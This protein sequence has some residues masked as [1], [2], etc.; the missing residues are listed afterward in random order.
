MVGDMFVVVFVGCQWRE[1]E[2][3]EERLDEKLVVVR[4]A[5]GGF[6]VLTNAP[7]ALCCCAP[8]SLSTSWPLFSPHPSVNTLL[9]AV[10]CYDSCPFI[11]HRAFFT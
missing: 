4:Q 5:H 8:E 3:E 9:M 10:P 1:E 2:E 7:W 11:K 6:V